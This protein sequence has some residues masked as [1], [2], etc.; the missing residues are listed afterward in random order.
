MQFVIRS[1][2]GAVSRRLW[3]VPLILLR[4]ISVRC[5]C[6]QLSIRKYMNIIFVLPNVY[7]FMVNLLTIYLYI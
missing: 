7:E 6:K 4:K 5:I 2:T 3:L 1:H